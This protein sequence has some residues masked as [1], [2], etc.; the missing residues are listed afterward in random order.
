MLDFFSSLNEN[1]KLN[2]LLAK[3]EK[4]DIF[5]SRILQL[6]QNFKIITK[7]RIICVCNSKCARTTVN[8]I[9]NNSGLIKK[10][11]YN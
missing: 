4:F 6:F 3:E 11:D 5:S 8:K 9:L 10:S 2:T 7:M 1:N